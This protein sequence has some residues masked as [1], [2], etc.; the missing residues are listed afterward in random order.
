VQPWLATEWEALDEARSYVF[1]LRDDVYFH[2]G[3]HMTAQTVQRNFDRIVDPDFQAGGSRGALTGYTGCDI[4]DEYTVQVN[5]ENPYAPFMS[6]AAAGTLAMISP[7]AAEEM[8]DDFNATPIGSGPFIIESYTPQQNCVLI[9]NAEYN[10]QS[11][12]S[13]REGPPLVER[14]EF[15][16]IPESATRVTTV[17]TGETH[18]INVVPSQD[19]PRLE[20]DDDIEVVKVP[21]VGIPSIL[22][23]NTQMP[24]TD[25]PLVRRAVSLAIDR[26][27]LVDTVYAGTAEVAQSA[28]TKVMLDDPS[29]DLPYD[30]DQARELLEEAGWVEGSGGVRERDGE[31]LT[32]LMN[33]IDPGAGISP[34]TQL[35]QANLVDVGFDVEL[36]VQAR[37]P[38]YEDNYNCATNGPIM[39]LR[40]GDYDGLFFMFHS[41]MI[42]ENF[43][44]AC[45][46]DPEIDELL[47][48]GQQET[49]PAAREAI[50]LEA[51]QKLEE[52]GASAP[53]VDEYAVWA[54]RSEVQGLKFN[55]LSYPVFGDLRIES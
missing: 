34:A 21:W 9:R 26:Q 30:P 32:F 44:F 45:L 28:L 12:Y 22:M 41:S 42:G 25:D 55:G 16:F 37:A 47:E 20:S 14:L 18:I 3:T 8:G 29:L 15:R 5:F 39:F 46:A 10:R 40:S 19:L 27:A 7:D 6:F 17:E 51:L 24:P 49:D 11:P 2:D 48:R 1:T 52:I 33:V 53:L 31:R 35:I 36:R 38:W 13:D 4:I 54:V 43:G 23:I 50:Y